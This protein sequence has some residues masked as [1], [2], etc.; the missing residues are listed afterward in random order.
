M[1]YYVLILFELRN[2]EMFSTAQSRDN[3]EQVLSNWD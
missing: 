2:H 1:N 3:V